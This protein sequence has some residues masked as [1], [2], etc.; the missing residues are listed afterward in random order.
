MIFVY[1]N[2]MVVH[3]HFLTR[4]L[5]SR[6]KIAITKNKHIITN[7]IAITFFICYFFLSTNDV[8]SVV[9]NISYP[10]A[11]CEDVFWMNSF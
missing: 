2:D 9:F 5:C 7:E 11:N 10:L 8:V 4:T 6:N 1:T 3:F